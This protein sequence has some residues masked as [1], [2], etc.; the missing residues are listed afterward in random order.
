MDDSEPFDPAGDSHQ[1]WPRRRTLAGLAA[2]GAGALMPGCATNGQTSAAQL[3]RNKA[4]VMR[5][6]KAQG[7]EL[8]ILL[9]LGAVDM[10]YG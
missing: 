2:L 8:G 1:V 7:D 6:K 10:L 4:V 9:Q 5:F 3:E